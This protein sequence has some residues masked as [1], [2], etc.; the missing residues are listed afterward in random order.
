MSTYFIRA[1]A[2]DATIISIDPL[3]KPLCAKAWDRWTP[4]S[5]QISLMGKEFIDF[6]NI[7][8]ENQPATWGLPV[9]WA[10]GA[11]AFF[12]D[13]MS[14]Y[15]RLDL[16]KRIGIRHIIFEDNY[17]PG[18]GDLKLRKHKDA[19]E[20]EGNIAKNPNLGFGM[21]QLL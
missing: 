21:K 19:R 9:D 15:H 8:W 3:E 13:H 14:S 20:W 17:L 5:G 1:A 7:D 6:Q 18:F 4:P 11:L 10:S 16:C 12:D 2:P